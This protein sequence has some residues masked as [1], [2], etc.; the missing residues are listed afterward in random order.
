MKT[1]ITY[2]IIVML[3]VSCQKGEN[4]PPYLKSPDFVTSKEDFKHKISIKDSITMHTEYISIR[5]LF[6]T[7][8][9]NKL[10]VHIY[11]K[12][13]V[14]NKPELN[15]AGENILKIALDDIANIKNYNLLEI[16]WLA[17]S[18][19]LKHTKSFEIK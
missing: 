7:S 14:L 12:R 8:S 13:Q 1:V 11:T 9:T 3:L 5:K 4:N 17:K 2:L 15:K 19:N 18:T 10:V 6:K 16:S